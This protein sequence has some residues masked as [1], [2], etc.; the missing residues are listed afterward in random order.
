MREYPAW[1]QRFWNKVQIG[2]PDE[3]WA[4]LGCVADPGYGRTGMP[5]VRKIYGAHRVAWHLGT[6]RPIS[7]TTGRDVCHTCDNRRCVNPSHLFLGTRTDNMRDAS[8]KGR[9][10]VPALRG[11][12]HAHSKLTDHLVSEM[13][14]SGE[15]NAYWARELGM[16]PSTIR[17]ARIPNGNW[18]HVQDISNIAVDG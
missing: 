11:E 10:V 14:N 6:G 5:G 1:P 17:R 15:T 16:N 18:R 3:C 8:R 4:W 12:Y 9:V 7:E 13:R 2:K